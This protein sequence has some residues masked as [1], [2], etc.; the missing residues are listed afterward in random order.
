ME[1]SPEY[2]TMLGLHERDHLL[3]DF[4]VEK[5]EARERYYGEVYERIGEIEK[6]VEECKRRKSKKVENWKQTLFHFEVFKEYISDCYHGFKYRMYMCMVNNV[7]GPHANFAQVISYMPFN[8][9]KDYNNYFSRMALFPT[10]IDQIIQLLT[11]AIKEKRIFPSNTMQ[12]VEKQI[13]EILETPIELSPFLKPLKSFPTKLQHLQAEYMAK[14]QALL[15]QAIYPAYKKFL[16]FFVGEYYPSAHTEIALSKHFPE[17]D[18]YDCLLRFHTGTDLTA[19]Q[20]FQIGK[21]EVMRIRKR[22]EEVI[23]KVGFKGTLKEFIEYLRTEK[24]FYFQTEKELM[25]YYRVI[26]KK[27]DPKL[28]K[29]IGKLPRAQYGI[30]KIPEQYAPSRNNA[31][32]NGP[33]VTGDRPGIYYVNTYKLE[34]R[35]KYEM[36][37]LGMQTSLHESSFSHL[38]AMRRSLGII[39]RFHW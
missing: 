24:Q 9:A 22:M 36:I 23:E 2:A 20:I 8:T 34:T 17:G 16:A 25:D 26:C 13:R 18:V 5:Y 33:S 7:E 21:D 4:S 38:L 31:Y 14:A 19:Q 10:Q 15:E 1:D 3:D 29:I 30:K 27:I 39:F 12:T 11:Q 32:Y 28:G 6:R 37:A 35:P